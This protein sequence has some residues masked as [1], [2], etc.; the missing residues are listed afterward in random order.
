MTGYHP[1]Y[2]FLESLGIAFGDDGYRTPVFDEA[3]FESS[4]AGRVPGRHGVRRLSDE[5][6]VHR[7]RPL[8]RPQIVKHIAHK[9]AEAVRFDEVHWKT[10]E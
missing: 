3:T 8:P 9:P 7:E 2:G 10:E 4:P 5:P 1:D 6:L